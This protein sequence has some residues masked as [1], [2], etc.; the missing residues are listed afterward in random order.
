LAENA[1]TREPLRVMIVDDHA[2]VRSGIRALLEL[3]PDLQV[4][5]EAAEVAEAVKG[6]EQARPDIVIMDVRL[7][8]GS[9]I[10]A[11]REI[12]A[13]RPE[14]RVL[15]LTSYADQQAFYASVMAGAAGFILKRVTEDELV[16]AVRVVARGES[17]LD[18]AITGGLL[19]RL[20]RQPRLLADEKMARLSGRE[21]LIL[22][23]VAQGLTNGE[24]GRKLGITE[25]TARNYV[26]SILGK[27]EV[28]RRA[29]AAAYLGRHSA[30]DG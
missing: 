23:L 25:R 5:A 11:A 6:A 22:D 7:G 2:V 12:R 18:P 19:E 14:V 10:E 28:S 24:I 29:E 27:L 21:E 1:Q 20:R 26:S 15:M 17:L 13:R 8:D 30:L 16:N 4:V 9:G 3:E